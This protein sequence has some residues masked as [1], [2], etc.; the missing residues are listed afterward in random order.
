MAPMPN[1]EE[2]ILQTRI[3]SSKEVQITGN[4]GFQQSKARLNL[5]STKSRPS[6]KLALMNLLNYN[7][8]LR[9]LEK[10]LNTSH[11]NWSSPGNQALMEAKKR[12]GG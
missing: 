11:P 9:K 2:E 8:K 1:E 10:G 4:N 3:V 7:K 6:V 5:F 12:R